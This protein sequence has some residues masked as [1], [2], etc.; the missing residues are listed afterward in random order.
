MASPTANSELRFWTGARGANREVVEVRKELTARITN[1]PEANWVMDRS[2]LIRESDRVIIELM[3]DYET[4]HEG[5]PFA[6]TVPD[7][8]GRGNKMAVHRAGLA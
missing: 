8:I 6:D 1:E 5:D 4:R 2:A 7:Y 3:Q